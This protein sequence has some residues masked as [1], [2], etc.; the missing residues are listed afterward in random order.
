MAGMRNTAREAE[1]GAVT[2][3]SV[4]HFDVATAF[5]LLPV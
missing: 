2:I 1:A 5:L 3:L 4:L